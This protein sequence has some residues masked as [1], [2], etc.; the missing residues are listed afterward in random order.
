MLC[1]KKM[2]AMATRTDTT[3]N[4]I[5]SPLPWP[6]ARRDGGRV[7]LHCRRH[8]HT[9]VMPA[10][11]PFN[12]GSSQCS[13]LPP[14]SDAE[15][16]ADHHRTR[17]EDHKR[18]GH[19]RRRLVQMMLGFVRDI[20]LAVEGQEHGPKHVER[21][22]AR[23]REPDHPQQARQP[24]RTDVRVEGAPQDLVLGEESRQRRNA[25]DGEGRDQKRRPGDLHML[26]A[27][28]S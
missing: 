12:T 6:P 21:G 20:V 13:M 4:I 8:A 18:H 11:V 23:G 10:H 16:K 9:D 7:R 27:G 28:P 14:R 3:I 15:P 22:H 25:G 24:R 19:D 26:R 5:S 1:A 17:C 2:P